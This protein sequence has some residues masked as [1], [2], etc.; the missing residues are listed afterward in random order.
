MQPSPRQY[1]RLQAE[2]I[3]TEEG[4]EAA[5][6]RTIQ[7]DSSRGY[8]NSGG[9]RGSHAQGNTEGPTDSSRGYKHRG[10]VRKEKE[11]KRK[12]KGN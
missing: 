4:P 10:G 3:K 12:V 8:K 5:R 2:A 11:T 6:P 1:I 9:A 7:K